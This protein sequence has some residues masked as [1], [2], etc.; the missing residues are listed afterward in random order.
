VL[1]ATG[2]LGS[3]LVIALVA[4]GARVRAASRAPIYPGRDTELARALEQCEHAAFALE[5][6]ASIERIVPPDGFVFLAAGLS[7]ALG[8]LARATADLEANGHGVLSV[9][10]ALRAKGSRAKVIFPSSQLVYGQDGSLKEDAPAR[11]LSVYAVHKLLGESYGRVYE[12]AHGVPFVSLRISNP[13]GPRQRASGGAYGLVRFFLDRA[14]AGAEVPVWGEGAQRRGYLYVTDVVSALLLA[15]ER[16]RGTYNI[17]HPESCSV[18]AMAEAVVRASGSGH[19]A[20]VPWPAEALKVESGDALLDCSRAASE[21][22]WSPRVPLDEGL[23]RTV[24][25]LRS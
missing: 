3:N 23:A 12:H 14:L 6:A 25:F 18:R 17:G 8:S 22:G 4:A 10:E 5:D 15:A 13:Y 21:L 11:P 20:S 24:A 19:V 1:G 2:F 9:L 16:G 7:G